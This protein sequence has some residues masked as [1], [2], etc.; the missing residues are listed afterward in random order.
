MKLFYWTESEYDTCNHHMVFADD[1]ETAKNFVM[2]AIKK[3]WVTDE[4]DKP[5]FWDAMAQE[6]ID[7]FVT[8]ENWKLEIID[9]VHGVVLHI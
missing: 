4:D 1:E 8:Q 9:I 5:D 7:K 6:E 3:S 2:D